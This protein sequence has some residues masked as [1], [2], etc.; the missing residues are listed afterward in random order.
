MAKDR[1]FHLPPKIKKRK[2]GGS[3]TWP[4]LL[5]LVAAVVVV[6]SYLATPDEPPD[7]TEGGPGSVYEYPRDPAQLQTI[8]NSQ[9]KASWDVFGHHREKT[10]SLII[11]A[12]GTSAGSLAVLG[13]GNCNDLD[14]PAIA[15]TY[16]DMYLFDIDEPALVAGVERQS[17]P[18]EAADRVHGR[19]ADL[20][21]ALDLLKA[22]NTMDDLTDATAAKAAYAIYNFDV[23]DVLPAASPARFDVVASTSMLTQLM[24]GIESAAPKTHG[25]KTAAIPVMVL[26]RNAHLR[27]MIAL[28]RPGGTGL[29]IS[30]FVSTLTLPAIT[31]MVDADLDQAL[32]DK[33]L[34]E[35]NFFTGCHPH[36]ILKAFGSEELA[37][38]V[39]N[40]RIEKMW[41]WQQS[42]G[43]HSLVAAFAFTKRAGVEYEK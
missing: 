18:K 38:F 20:S 40:L 29:L 23:K 27:H 7:L 17:L 15:S 37:P 32:L 1:A 16:T 25:S 33:L 10:T 13:A 28:L 11:G 26:Q 4:Y 5:L 2:R 41:K 36:S 43:T 35:K 39:E 19:I 14:L 8:L 31:R 9:T 12:A 42:L 22:W 6:I 30:E 34:R 24:R 3:Y 21:G